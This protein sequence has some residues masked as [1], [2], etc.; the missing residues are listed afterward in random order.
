VL[1]IVFGIPLYLIWA[2]IATGVFVVVSLI[3]WAVSRSWRRGLR[4]GGLTFAAMIAPG[5]M[6]RAHNERHRVVNVRI[7]A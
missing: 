5:H 3:A 1:I 6:T 7:V 4:I 2:C